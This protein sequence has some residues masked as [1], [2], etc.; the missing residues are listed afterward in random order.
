M[1]APLKGWVRSWLVS[2]GTVGGVSLTNSCFTGAGSIST[3][4]PLV[5]EL[6]SWHPFPVSLRRLSSIWPSC[7][8]YRSWVSKVPDSNQDVK[9]VLLF[10]GRKWDL[11][12]TPEIFLFVAIFPDFN[13]QECGSLETLFGC[14]LMFFVMCELFFTPVWNLCLLNPL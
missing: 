4:A 13:D 1:M 9:V 8:L 2:L 5:V 3:L 14:F 10:N 11:S 6:V 7:H 12:W